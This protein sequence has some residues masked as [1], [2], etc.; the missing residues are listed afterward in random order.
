[1]SSAKRWLATLSGRLIVWRFS[2]G[3]RGFWEKPPRGGRAHKLFF[4]LYRGGTF[5]QSASEASGGGRGGGGGASGPSVVVNVASE[6]RK[7]KSA[8]AVFPLGVGGGS[9]SVCCMQRARRSGV[10]FTLE[11]FSPVS[12]CFVQ[13]SARLAPCLQPATKNEALSTFR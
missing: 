13:K 4:D 10:D 9:S 1:M 6:K 12:T 2:G 5:L 7:S 11:G 3:P 8:V